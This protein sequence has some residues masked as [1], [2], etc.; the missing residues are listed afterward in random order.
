VPP[1]AYHAATLLPGSGA[2]T[3]GAR[4]DT[5]ATATLRSGDQQL[6]LAGATVPLARLFPTATLLA[7]G[8]F[9]SGGQPIRVV[10]AILASAELFDPRR[11]R[12]SGADAGAQRI[13]TRRR[14]SGGKVIVTGGSMR[15]AE[16]RRRGSLRSGEQYMV[17]R[18]RLAHARDSIARPG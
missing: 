8:R 10:G 9:A 13:S 16:D 11:V 12:G 6:D 17:E 1:L 2:L 5:R 3:V 7:D 14:C 18:R 4:H 15:K